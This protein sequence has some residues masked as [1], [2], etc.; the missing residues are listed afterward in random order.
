MF[1]TRRAGRRH[2]KSEPL[3]L[4]SSSLSNSLSLT[5][6]CICLILC[7]SIGMW[8]TEEGRL[9]VELLFNDLNSLHADVQQKKTN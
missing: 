6:D 4:S 7:R 9:M 2:W 3:S 8:I 1:V 5:G